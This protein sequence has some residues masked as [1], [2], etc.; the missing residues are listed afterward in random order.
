MKRGS[1]LS[2]HTQPEETAQSGPR[3]KPL[4]LFDQSP[5]PRGPESLGMGAEQGLIHTKAQGWSL[6]VDQSSHQMPSQEILY[7]WHWRVGSYLGS[8]RPHLSHPYNP[9]PRCR[10][11]TWGRIPRSPGN[12]AHS[13]GISELYSVDLGANRSDDITRMPGVAVCLAVC[14]VVSVLGG[15]V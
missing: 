3:L 11:E 12:C 7:L 6:I 1:D 9:G 4:G 8:E 5:S 2:K 10:D 13:E 15:W 14:L